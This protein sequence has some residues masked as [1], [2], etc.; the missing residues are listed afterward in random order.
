MFNKR[1]HNPYI[2]PPGKVMLV[3]IIVIMII[4]IIIIIIII[5]QRQLKKN[6][7]CNTSVQNTK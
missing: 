5:P 7:Q 6:S 1:V 3:I 2:L 4:I